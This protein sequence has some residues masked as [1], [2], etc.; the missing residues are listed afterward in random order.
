M[1]SE[2]IKTPCGFEIFIVPL[3]DTT[4]RFRVMFEG[5][6]VGLNFMNDRLSEEG[7]LMLCDKGREMY[8]N[9]RV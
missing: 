1:L 9:S 6:E 2:K 4:V 3:A 7:F 5:K 8:G